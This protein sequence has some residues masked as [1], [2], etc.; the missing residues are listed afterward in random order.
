[1][2]ALAAARKQLRYELR[3]AH[4]GWIERRVA[5]L[6]G[7]LAGWNRGA[8]REE[9]CR[10]YQESGGADTP[11]GV[12]RKVAQFSSACDRGEQGDPLYSIGEE[13]GNEEMI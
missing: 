1:M 4:G 12:F 8:T 11:A 10:R 6:T 13:W 2:A 9:T 3:R 5:A 7:G